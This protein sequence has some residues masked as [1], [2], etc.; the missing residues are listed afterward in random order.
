MPI[1]PEKTQRELGW[2]QIVNALAELTRSPVGKEHAFALP[3]LDDGDQVRQ[4][5]A[6]VAEGRRLNAQ[7]LEIPLA[8]A[9]DAR[10]HLSRAAREGVLEAPSLLECARLIRTSVRVR[11]FL[12]SRRE[13]V[14]ML[15]GEAEELSEF[16]PLASEIERAIEPSGALS[17]HASPLLADLRERS[18]GL[19]RNLKTRIDDILH[20]E[21]LEEVLRDTYYTIRDE[22]YVVPVKSSHRARLPGIVH[23][24]SQSGQT[25][26]VEP[27]QLID[28]GNQLTIAQAMALEEERRI[29][30]DLTDAVGRRATEL[31]RDTEI[32]ASLD[33]VGASARLSDRLQAGEPE[34]VAPQTPFE[35]RRL[36]HPLLALRGVAVVANDVLLEDGKSGFIVSGPNAGGKTVTLTAVGLAALMLRAGLPIP[37][38][39]GSKMPLY[40]AVHTAIGDEGD[41]AK[42]LSTF[43]AHLTALREIAKE[44][45]PG[46]LVC[47]DEIAADTDPREGAAL[48]S[49]MLELL[50]DRG[51]HVLITTHL[52]EVKAKGLTDARFMSASVGFDFDRLA[53]TYRLKLNEVGASSAIEIARRVGVPE[54]VCNRARELLS[55]SGGALDS[56]VAELERERGEVAR[57]NSVLERER[58][59]LVRAR[60]EW[61]RQ[62]DALKQK[63]REVV[64]GA[65]RELLTELEAVRNE[66][67]RTIA[68]LQQQQTM[69]VAVDTQK[70][71]EALA[72]V[73]EAAAAKAAAEAQAI[74]AREL[75]EETEL[76]PGLRVRVASVGQEGEVL[77]IDGDTVTVSLGALKTRVP[78]SDVVPL[79]G[80]TTNVAALRRTRAEKIEAAQRS[81]P[82]AVA[83]LNARLDL[84]GLRSEDA[85]R[86]LRG[87]LD[88]AFQGELKEL[89]VVHGHGTG[90][91]KAAVRE[92][93][94]SSPYVATFRPGEGHEGGDGVTVIA[95]KER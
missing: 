1:I 20:D 75:S 85:L 84:R 63:E 4:Q 87:Q 40:R 6:R 49:A 51:A 60:E 93:L 95:L 79:T 29:L 54:S 30:R 81:R 9:P 52:D 64:A 91:L 33:R 12:H 47:V 15:A 71:V 90:A 21:M 19:H 44:T 53:P 48:A 86:A 3:F 65:R 50:I 32:M 76:K 25:L 94:D 43:T 7:D 26:F 62:R 78:T 56:A 58:E 14:P 57:L 69:R 5:L 10:A 74:A 17:D 16:D 31:L 66:V 83:H 46:T 37:A 72:A 80:R 34:V 2:P 73:Q 18:R 59:A 27:E 55:G 28:L 67:R 39:R 22:R 92:E 36:R 77:G 70:K 13:L 11:R 8:D 82:A 42:D 23:N 41:L 61:E 45:I 68:Q 38:E 88:Q 89:L 35:L 24:A